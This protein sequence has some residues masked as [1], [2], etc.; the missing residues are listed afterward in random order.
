MLASLAKMGK[1]VRFRAKSENEPPPFLASEASYGLSN[2]N[3]FNIR[4]IFMTR[5][6]KMFIQPN[7]YDYP[8]NNV[9]FTS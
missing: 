3:Y 8:D 5:S 1:V 2:C 6:V 4:L 9:I 7:K